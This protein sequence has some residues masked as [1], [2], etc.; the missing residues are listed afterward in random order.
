MESIPSF[1]SHK[2]MRFGTNSALAPPVGIG[3]VVVYRHRGN[4]SVG[5]GTSATTSA[6]VG[7]GDAMTLPADLTP[8]AVVDIPTTAVGELLTGPHEWSIH[9]V[10]VR[11]QDPTVYASAV[12]KAVMNSQHQRL[13]SC[14]YSRWTTGVAVESSPG[15][16][17]AMEPEEH[18]VTPFPA[19][20]VVTAAHLNARLEQICAM[21]TAGQPLKPI[22]A[23]LRYLAD[24]LDTIDRYY[25]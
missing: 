1:G 24:A 7:H 3:G 19:G 16:S 10:K 5:L 23:E 15:E 20:S 4:P 18:H 25:S 17:S 22:I 6:S 14:H 11:T 21:C 9:L 13:V 8:T 12:I 2:S